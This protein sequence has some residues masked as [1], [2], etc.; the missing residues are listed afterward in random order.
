MDGIVP[1]S[2]FLGY[3]SMWAMQFMPWIL[4]IIALNWVLTLVITFV[5]GNVVT[6]N[7]RARGR[8][9]KS[10]MNETWEIDPKF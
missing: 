4:A 3:L 8:S 10:T 9:L 6:S 7:A 1:G 5:G 2:E